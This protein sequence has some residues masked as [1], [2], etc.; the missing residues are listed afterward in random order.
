MI[1]CP[2]I[3]L[4][5]FIICNSILVDSLG[6][7]IYNITSSANK[8]YFISSFPILIPCICFSCL[9][10]LGRSFSLIFDRNSRIKCRVWT[11][12][13][14]PCLNVCRWG[15][16]YSFLLDFDYASQEKQSIDFHH[17]FICDSWNFRF[18]LG[19]PDM[20][21]TE[22][23]TWRKAKCKLSPPCTVSFYPICTGLEWNTS[24]IFGSTDTERGEQ[25]VGC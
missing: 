7:C 19:L 17:S 18:Q 9:V 25:E 4:N 1:L 16:K 10:A 24:S 12:T 11:L 6:F 23:D 3:F 14:L 22:E 13:S 2:A 21:G 8:A 5:F 15:L 20:G